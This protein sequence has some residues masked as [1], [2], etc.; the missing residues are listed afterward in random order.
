MF[1][2]PFFFASFLF[3]L[4]ESNFWYWRREEKVSETQ[5]KFQDE[6]YGTLLTSPFISSYYVNIKSSV[7]YLKNGPCK[8]K[9]LRCRGRVRKTGNISFTTG[10]ESLP[11][12]AWVNSWVFLKGGLNPDT[13]APPDSSKRLNPGCLDLSTHRRTTHPLNAPPQEALR[14]VSE[15]AWNLQ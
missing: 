10:L 4:S 6:S 7:Q 13:L 5:L 2:L 3:F 11:R 1:A 12:N 9:Q 8:R 14:P 15:A